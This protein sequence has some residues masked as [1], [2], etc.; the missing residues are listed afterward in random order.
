MKQDIEILHTPNIEDRILTRTADAQLADGIR[1]Y[2]EP[3]VDGMLAEVHK[4]LIILLTEIVK[5]GTLEIYGESRF[6]R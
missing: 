4:S 6:A 2:S 5:R 1:G 3:S